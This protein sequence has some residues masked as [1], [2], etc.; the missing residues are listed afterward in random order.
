MTGLEI[1]GLIGL[2][3]WLGD[4]I[5]AELKVPQNSAWQVVKAVFSALS[6]L[7]K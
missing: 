5:L 7:K 1:V 6:K 4:N 2:V 3:G